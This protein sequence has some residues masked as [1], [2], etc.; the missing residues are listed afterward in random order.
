[1]FTGCQYQWRNLCGFGQCGWHRPSCRNASDSGGKAAGTPGRSCTSMT[2]GEF[3]KNE[4]SAHRA[5]KPE[6]VD[7]SGGS[8][9]RRLGEW[10][11]TPRGAYSRKVANSCRR[12]DTNRLRSTSHVRC[13]LFTK[14]VAKF[15]SSRTCNCLCDVVYSFIYVAKAYIQVGVVA[16]IKEMSFNCL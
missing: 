12:C 1:M 11:C 2:P 5:A 7:A 6:P 14:R 15:A 10:L 9:E 16:N 3:V 13:D 8:R 4:N